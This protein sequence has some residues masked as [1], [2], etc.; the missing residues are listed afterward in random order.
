MFEN[1]NNSQFIGLAPR[2]FS[3]LR[4][5][6]EQAMTAWPRGELR[7]SGKER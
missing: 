7:D 6:A 3:G 5:G 2:N 1:K 4:P